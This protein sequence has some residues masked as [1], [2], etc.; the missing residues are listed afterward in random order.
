MS[1]SGLD[2]VDDVE[3]KIQRL[4]STSCGAASQSQCHKRRIVG[5]FQEVGGSEGV[6]GHVVK[7]VSDSLYWVHLELTRVLTS[8]QLRG[9]SEKLD[10][11]IQGAECIVGKLG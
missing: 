10:H 1:C 3:G 9:R 5:D 4:I 8:V 7:A 2:D 11:H 6:R